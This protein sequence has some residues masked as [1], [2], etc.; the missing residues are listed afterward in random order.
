[1]LQQQ[2]IALSLESTDID[3]QSIMLD[4]WEQN[5]IQ[6][7]AGRFRAKLF[8]LS[9]SN[10]LCVFRKFTNRRIH[11]C[12]VSPGKQLRLATVLPNSDAAIFQGQEILPGD[13]FAIK[14][15]IESELICR[16]KF[17]VAAIELDKGLCFSAHDTHHSPFI[18]V[19]D[20]VKKPDTH[21]FAKH[22]WHAFSCK[23]IDSTTLHSISIPVIKA[24]F[25]NDNQ[26]CITKRDDVLSKAILFTER[27]F[28]ESGELPKVPEIALYSGM[29]ERSL[30]YAFSR[31]YG[32]SPSRFF[33]FRRLHGARRDIRNQ[34]LSV[35]DAAMKW[36]FNHLG[37]FSGSYR[38]FF[39]ELPSQ[40]N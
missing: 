17:D 8:S 40:T 19:K 30:E 36:G 27:Y 28:E 35:T 24:L 22:L 14:P 12:F 1:M 31:K 29:S 39:G 6:L 5:Y 33:T 23:E 9:I 26:D 38:D 11:K 37:R 34:K 16:G 10:E 13:V 20:V 4:G 21:D 2:N 7:E 3:D 15:N 32:V 18:H 25:C